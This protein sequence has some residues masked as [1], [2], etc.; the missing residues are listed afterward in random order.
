MIPSFFAVRVK[1]KLADL[2]QRGLDH[3]SR[4]ASA[5]RKTASVAC[6]S[7]EENIHIID[8]DN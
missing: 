5:P 6:L 4:T 8:S 7:A 3:V 1:L 2:C